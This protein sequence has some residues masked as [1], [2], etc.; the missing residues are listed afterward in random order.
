LVSCQKPDFK[1]NHTLT[2]NEDSLLF[3]NPSNFEVINDTTF[4][5]INDMQVL[6]KYNLKTGKII[7]S[8]NFKDSLKLKRILNDLIKTLPK[9]NYTIV[10]NKELARAKFHSN[11]YD[12]RSYY[13]DGKYYYIYSSFLIPYSGNYQEYK[14][15]VV[16]NRAYTL[17]T[18]DNKFNI[19]NIKRFSY[20]FRKI[21]P[22]I[23]SGFIKHNNIL[24]SNNYVILSSN[25]IDSLY[26]VFN[27]IKIDNKC[28]TINSTPKMIKEIHF[29]NNSYI[30]EYNNTLQNSS[31]F[32]LFNDS[33]Y[34]TVAN[35]IYNVYSKKPILKICNNL[36]ISDFEVR[37]DDSSILFVSISRDAETKE[38]Y[39]NKYYNNKSIISKKINTAKKSVKLNCVYNNKI[40]LLTKDEENYYVEEYSI[41]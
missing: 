3:I 27:K 22:I 28:D 41:D 19:K 36:K 38:F 5:I 15:V 2:I 18:T 20:Y 6:R 25:K 37:N 8:F 26:P 40:Y 4:T 17:I 1:L 30:F 33:L 11:T 29:P 31:K 14:D 10:T 23:T 35:N 34:A 24:Y 9:R 21:N 39:L 12:L 32:N 16:S 7:N 13:F